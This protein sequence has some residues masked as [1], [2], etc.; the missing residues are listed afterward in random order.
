MS[1][2][3]GQISTKLTMDDSQFRATMNQ[4]LGTTKAFATKMDALGGSMLKFSAPLVAG[5][6]SASAGL[7]KFGQEALRIGGGFE[8]AMTRVAAISGATGEEFTVLSNKARELGAS[9]P[10]MAQ[11]AAG[12]MEVLASRGYSAGKMLSVV[13]DIVNLS[14]AQ[15]YDL[16]GSADLVSAALINYQMAE[17]DAG[18]V[19]DIFTQASNR[20]ALSM[21]K[22]SYAMRYAAAPA[23]AMGES[24]ESTVAAMGALAD[25]GLASMQIGTTLRGVY[26]TIAQNAEVL[27]VS[28]RN[29]EGKLRSLSEVMG[30]I[31]TK[32]YGL[33][34]FTEAF[35]VEIATG[36]LILSKS[37][38][39]IKGLNEELANSFGATAAQVEKQMQTWE[40]ISKGFESRVES[41]YL[42]VFDQIKNT[43]KTGVLSLTELTSALEKWV[44]ETEVAGKSLEA[45][46]RGLGFNVP[47]GAGIKELLDSID[48]EGIA[49]KF[50]SAG[51]MLGNFGETIA[52]IAGSVPWGL[53]LGNLDLLMKAGFWS[54]VIGKGASFVSIAG[55]IGAA[56]GDW[57]DR[58]SGLVVSDTAATAAT[59][60][61]TAA[62]AANATTTIA[63]SQADMVKM[64]TDKEA[65]AI[66][67][68]KTKMEKADV[69][70]QNAR[71]NATKLA[72]MA[73]QAATAGTQTSTVMIELNTKAKNANAAASMLQGKAD[74]ARAAYNTAAAGAGA[75]A[76]LAG[77]EALKTIKGLVPAAAAASKSVSL[78]ELAMSGLSK[79]ILAVSTPAGMLAGTVALVGSTAVSMIQQVRADINKVAVEAE[80]KAKQAEDHLRNLK[81]ALEAAE[82][83]EFGGDWSKT[84]SEE[85][86]ALKRRIE[87]A[88][89]AKKEYEYQQQIGQE[90][91]KATEAVRD[92]KDPLGMK[93]A[94]TNLEA[95]QNKAQDLLGTLNQEDEQWRII[96]QLIVA[97]N[98][99][100]TRRDELIEGAK[101]KP[102]DFTTYDKALSELSEETREK[103]SA[104]LREGLTDK[105]AIKA[106]ESVLTKKIGEIYE[107]I[108][109]KHGEV[110]A[111]IWKESAERSVGLD[112]PSKEVRK[113]NQELA[114][115]R[116]ELF[117]YQ[118]Y[119]RQTGN[120]S[121][122]A[123]GQ[124]EQMTNALIE[125][126]TSGLDV[127]Q[128]QKLI[129]DLEKLGRQSGDRYATAL[130]EKL[131]GGTQKAIDDAKQM[132][133]AT[134][135]TQDEILSAI[136]KKEAS[137]ERTTKRERP[138]F[139]AAGETEIEVQ[140]RI[141]KLNSEEVAAYKAG[142]AAKMKA[143]QDRLNAQAALERQYAEQAIKIQEDADKKEAERNQRLGLGGATVTPD[144]AKSL[145]LLG[146]VLP[147]ATEFLTKGQADYTTSYKAGFE[148]AAAASPIALPMP[149]I[150]MD[151]FGT[152]IV[153]QLN[154]MA[155]TM[156]AVL[157]QVMGTINLNPAG[158]KVGKTFTDGIIA[159]V[160]DGTFAKNI[161]DGLYEKFSARLQKELADA[162]GG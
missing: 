143:V 17:T 154:A 44:S 39:K 70:A 47:E 21:E 41:L 146:K 51:E 37:V 91:I 78:L 43:S 92:A 28:T 161:L 114:K 95:F 4:A 16:A 138:K 120:T 155:P 103:L 36:A 125:Q 68:L 66:L 80:K 18:K 15:N 85:R 136:E 81:T 149:K 133:K 62:K 122:Y 22:L 20:S 87:R 26:G 134:S 46:V 33:D 53:L 2:E 25:A 42:T 54:W 97:S 76:E 145:E 129:D 12:A 140:G 30:E 139:T 59:T 132:V 148:Q 29:A 49:A 123:A 102:P 142:D 45:F 156:S 58:L 13:G 84:N 27:G 55:S 109:E 71:A 108:K 104:G 69:V 19:A 63:A 101:P 110:T 118:Q 152:G 11:D 115:A 65:A 141:A 77:T 82:Q 119:L 111:E 100:L 105:T 153:T 67:A 96:N 24:L 3:A 89:A 38:D 74:A 5:I 75:A 144:P 56:I 79:G 99:L 158:L 8:A 147:D 35:G 7:A 1:F 86:E 64:A 93:V 73:E 116:N 10:I 60:A 112:E 160:N 131:K 48:V 52:N 6:A 9:L 106:Y 61:D 124:L 107:S 121:Q 113:F 72:A 23:A 31:S 135:I 83:G 159:A 32:G 40:N 57:A 126:A 137:A 128:R 150:N 98:E 162:G 130:A 127:T 88:E 94:L 117:T 34:K 90:L 157:S 14:I 151:T 50:E